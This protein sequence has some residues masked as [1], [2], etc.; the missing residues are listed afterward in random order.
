MT[1]LKSELHHWWPRCVSSHWAAEDGKTGWLKPDGTFKRLPP[2]HL[3]VIRDG[4]HI[5]LGEP[6]VSTL[7]DSSFEDEF[8]R[9]D[10]HF[11]AVI[12]WL[13]GLERRVVSRGDFRSQF[14]SQSVTDEQLRH[15]TECVVSL[16]VR[17]PMN[18]EASVA[19]AEYFRGPLP[20]REREA[21][22]AA[23]MR[24]SQRLAADSIG[25]SAKFAVLFS[26]GRE[27]V[28][29]DGFFHNVTAVVDRPQMPTIVAPITPNIS[30]VVT[31]PM[32]YM[33]DPRLSTIL[34]TGEEVEVC[35]SA[36]QVYAR[37]AIYF[38][39]DRP[40]V[41]EDFARAQHLRYSHPN[42]PIAEMVRSIPGIPPR[43]TSFDSLFDHR[44]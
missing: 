15:L 26:H 39:H 31:R 34:L 8:D 9:A 17:S 27:F 18:R 30:V 10:S 4:H 3:G 5:K 37:N 6:G 40:S 29:G 16:A 1:K 28:F 35:N 36:V 41:S 43:D 44:P 19:T 13:E 7:W 32:S 11:P 42:N 25:A 22:I 14:L 21:L 33:V 20:T 24:N 38:R 2:H 12:S 23:N